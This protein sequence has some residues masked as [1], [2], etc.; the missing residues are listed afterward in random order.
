MQLTYSTKFWLN[1]L[2]IWLFQME[3]NDWEMF[4]YY[5]F[6]LKLGYGTKNQNIRTWN[7]NFSK[8]TIF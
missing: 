2:P 4:P 1:R 8:E 5:V 3:Y 6:S 7:A